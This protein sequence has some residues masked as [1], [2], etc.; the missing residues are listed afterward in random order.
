MKKEQQELLYHSKQQ[1]EQV[2]KLITNAIK[3]RSYSIDIMERDLYLNEL[4][5][6]HLKNK[7]FN[8]TP[9]GWDY[10]FTISW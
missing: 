10:Y 6:E 2:E 3:E 5:I 1:I 4:T 8:V 9:H 7:G